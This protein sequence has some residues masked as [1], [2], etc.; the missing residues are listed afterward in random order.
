MG[1]SG[2][3]TEAS[4]GGSKGK[5]LH[6]L[7]SVSAIKLSKHAIFKALG[8]HLPHGLVE[9]IGLIPKEIQTDS[10]LVRS[11]ISIIQDRLHSLPFRGSLQSPE[12]L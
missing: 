12:R 6:V 10:S 8:F 5:H 7:G 2:Q 1:S 9:W 3:I 11:G 4:S